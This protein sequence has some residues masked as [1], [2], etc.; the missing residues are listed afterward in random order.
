MKK[1]FQKIIRLIKGINAKFELRE[2]EDIIIG[3]VLIVLFMIVFII[4]A[5]NVISNQF[6]GY[7]EGYNATVAASVMRSGIYQVSYPAHIVFYNII[8]TGSTVLLPTALIYRFFGISSFTTK[9]VPVIYGA[10]CVLLF[11]IF[12]KMCLNK[13]RYKNSMAAVL[14]ILF[15]L[16]EKL[17]ETISTQL[18][19]E[20]GCLF[21]LIVSLIFFIFI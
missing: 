21:F 2:K 3:T 18:I 5:V 14:T 11:W 16:S 12:M 7:D 13:F 6:I 9:I 10:L 20:I 1:G 4:D 15:I 17:Y 19:G 8:T